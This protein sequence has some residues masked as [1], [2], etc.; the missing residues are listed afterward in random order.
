MVR[1]KSTENSMEHTAY[2]KK[3]RT[4]DI[5]FYVL[6]AFLDQNIGLFSGK[7]CFSFPFTSHYIVISENISHLCG[8]ISM[9]WVH[10]H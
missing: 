5:L 3:K 7:Y 6:Y 8:T 4:N 1:L 9:P 2:K 10:F